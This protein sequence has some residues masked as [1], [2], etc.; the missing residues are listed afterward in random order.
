MIDLESKM[1]NKNKLLKTFVKLPRKILKKKYNM[2]TDK[3]INLSGQNANDYI[4][5]MICER[6][7]GLMV[8]KFGTIELHNVCCF[9]AT[10]KGL[11]LNNFLM[12]CTGE[13][14]LYPEVTM[15][16]LCSNAGFFP[17]NI[18]LGYQY[19]NL[20]IS[21][22]KEIDILGSYLKEEEYFKNHLKHCVKVDLEG[23]YA[24]FLWENP[25]SSALRGKKILVIHPFVNS[26]EKQYRNRSKLFENEEVLPEF[27]DLIL[28]KAV[29][30]IAG[31]DTGFTNWF[32][33]LEYMKNKIDNVDF[34]IA[35]IGCGA[36]GMNLAAHIKRRGKI[37]IH[38]AGWTQMLFGIY[39]NRWIEDRPEYTK[40]I[41]SYW[42]RPSENEKP[43]GAEKIE[44]A[45]YW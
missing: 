8:S 1:T 42:I 23:Y 17:R 2:Y 15:Q 41:N 19:K 18:T 10:E 35:L 28:I 34:D 20:V 16:S 11:S 4:R 24:P 38:M 5:K 36:Y 30:S 43:F 7:Q 37:A 22:M 29:Q 12:A 33:A 25:W 32:E 40:Y 9:D 21:D 39:G 26:I 3:Y 31:N 14:S 44:N 6:P 27:G 45:C 13:I